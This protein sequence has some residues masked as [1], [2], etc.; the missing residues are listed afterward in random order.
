M[1]GLPG[2]FLVASPE[3][4][5]KACLNAA[6]KKRNL[7]YFPFFWGPI[8]GIIKAIPEALFKRLK[9]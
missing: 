2:M 3:A 9:L 1:Y 6:A 7:L 4:A 5:A 8:M